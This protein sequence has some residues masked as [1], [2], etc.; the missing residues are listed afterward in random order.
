MNMDYELLKIGNK[1]DARPEQL[2][3]TLENNMTNSGI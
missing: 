1:D 2:Y 3:K